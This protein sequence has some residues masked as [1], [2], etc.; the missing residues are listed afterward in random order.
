MPDP[1]ATIVLNKANAE[2][3]AARREL[4]TLCAKWAE[5]N[6]T[7]KDIARFDLCK[8]LVRRLEIAEEEICELIDFAE[9]R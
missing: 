2:I 5:I 6:K 8:A 4:K 9:E 3:S 7:A 1:G